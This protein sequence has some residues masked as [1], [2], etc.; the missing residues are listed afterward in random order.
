[1]PDLTLEQLTIALTAVAGVALVAFLTAILLA[2]RLRRLRKHY[3]LLRGDGEERDILQALVRSTKEVDSVERRIDE[4]AAAQQELA[5]LGKFGLQKF[6]LV[7]YDAFEDMGGQMSFSAAMLDDHGDGIV[8]TSINGRTETR[9]Y[10][11]SIYA[12]GSEH[13]LSDEEREVIEA[14]Y[15][16]RG[17]ERSEAGASRSR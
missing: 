6:A 17:R 8:I 2:L 16:G 13:N 4:V 9:T 11:K 10:A 5:A 1:M 3:A 15:V 12:R 14:A 7:R